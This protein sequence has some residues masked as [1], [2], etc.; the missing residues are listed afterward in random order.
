MD[1]PAIAVPVSPGAA[2]GR[3]VSNAAKRVPDF[4]DLSS[5]GTEHQRHM[6]TTK[7]PVR[8]GLWHLLFQS[9]ATVADD[10]HVQGRSEGNC[11]NP[12]SCRAPI[13]EF[14]RRFGRIH[15]YRTTNSRAT[16]L[17]RI[18]RGRSRDADTAPGAYLMA[19]AGPGRTIC[20]WQM[21]DPTSTSSAMQRTVLANLRHLFLPEHLS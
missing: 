8:C 20:M 9:S 21:A 17:G 6:T 16:F 10:H 12:L 1:R 13:N 3:P 2:G 19:E 15:S 18:P 14:G 5:T 11:K 7:G 4:K